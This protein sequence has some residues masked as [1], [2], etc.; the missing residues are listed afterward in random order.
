MTADRPIDNP[1]AWMASFLRDA[2]AAKA[3]KARPPVTQTSGRRNAVAI[4]SAPAINGQPADQGDDGEPHQPPAGV[5]ELLVETLAGV[6]PKPVEWTVPD[7][8][9][10]GMMGL[11]AGEG[12]HGKSML[13]LELAAAVSVG[14]CA[15]GL[16]YPNP[17]H[18]KALLICCEDDW[19]RTT[20]PRLAALGA[21]FSRVLRQRGVR[22]KAGGEV[23][24]FHLGHFR[25]LERLLETHTDI[26]VVVVDPAGAY[27]G[28][29]GVNENRDAD[30]RSVLG[31]LS[32]AANR[33]RSTVLLVKHLNKTAGASAVQRVS[34]SAG[35][36]N[37]VRFAYMVAPDPDDCG[38]KL[39]FPMKTN[40][41][42]PGASGFAYRMNAIPPNEGRP[43]LLAKWPDL[44]EPD[45]GKLADQLFRQTWEHGVTVDPNEVGSRQR[46]ESS[47]AEVAGCMDYIRAFLGGWS[48]PEASLEAAVRDK[49]F[50]TRVYKSAKA[51]MRK[52]PKDDPERLSSKPRGEGGA[53]WCWIGPQGKPSPDSHAS[54]TDHTDPV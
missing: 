34:G 7:A 4:T 54:H 20:A 17:V 53:W 48:F 24:D 12:G 37:A 41:L 44:E 11:I 19:E 47:A 43:L 8:I 46:R 14:R 16:S 30:L 36:I 45:L 2:E 3:K 1:D 31:P 26:R 23:M 28:R 22:L 29:A 49:G 40:I 9:P 6:R 32:E 13:T 51:E 27:I 42:P 52:P 15:F 38:R 18:G 33:T 39:F 10:A 5:G 21:D 25:E 35:Y 50:A